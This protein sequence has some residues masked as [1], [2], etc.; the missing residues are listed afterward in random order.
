MRAL[1]DT[2]RIEVLRYCCPLSTY[3]IHCAFPADFV[4]PGF[5]LEQKTKTPLTK[6][7]QGTDCTISE[8]EA[9]FPSSEKVASLIIAAV[10]KGDFIICKDSL[11]ASLLFTNMIG[12][13][14]KRGWGIADSLLSL[15]IGWFVWPVLRRRWEGITREDGEELRRSRV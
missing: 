9:R 7:I 4:S 5:L 2:L 8:L 14:P 3:S 11:A 15:V 10:D 12:P 1:A 13:S 6:R